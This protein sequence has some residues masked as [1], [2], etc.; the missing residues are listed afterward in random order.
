MPCFSTEYFATA[1][2]IVRVK[3]GKALRAFITS[4][5]SLFEIIQFGVTQV[6]PNRS[7]YTAILILDKKKREQISFRRIKKIAAELT[8]GSITY[9]NYNS[10]EYTEQPWIFVSKANRPAGA[11]LYC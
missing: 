3:G 7:T 4:H 5:S 6:F 8:A 11:F 2:F 1:Y 9:D 10:V